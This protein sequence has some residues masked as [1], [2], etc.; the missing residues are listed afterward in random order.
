MVFF[1]LVIDTDI[2]F[3]DALKAFEDCNNKQPK[4]V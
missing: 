4:C 1:N 3:K 2:R